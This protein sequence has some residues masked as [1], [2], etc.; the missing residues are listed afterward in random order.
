MNLHST[1]TLTAAAR[2]LLVSTDLLLGDR[3][4]PGQGAPLQALDP[5]TEQVLAT[6]PSASVQQVH[7]AVARAREAFDDG[8]WPRLAPA[9]R[10]RVLARAADLMVQHRQ[11]LMDIAVAEGGT[12]VSQAGA[13]KVDVSV[14]HLRWFAAK[15]AEGPRAGWERELAA[16]ARWPG[17]RSLLLREPIGVVAALTPYNVQYLTTVWKVIGALA[18]GCTTVFMP[19]PRAQLAGIAFAR[20]L[21]MAGLPRGAFNLVLGGPDVGQALTE[22][23]GV[24]LVSFTGSNTVGRKVMVQAAGSFK[25]VVLELGGKSPNV[26]LPGAFRPAVVP[27]SILRFCRSAGQAC[28]ATTRTFVPQAD[29]ERYVQAARE[30]LR[31]FKVGDPWDPATAM[32]PLIRAEHRAGVEGY[33]QR[34]LAAGG[35]IEAGGGRPDV[36]SGFFMNPALVGGVGNDS[37]IAQ[38]E[39][40]G[41]VGV[42]IPYRDVDEAVRL[43]NDTRYGL[44][45]NVWG[46]EREALAVARRIRSGSVTV[47]G[48]GPQRPDAPFGGYKQS[49]FGSEL[50]EEGFCEF[51]QVQHVQVKAG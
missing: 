21:A 33:V 32:G 19:A 43:A 4:T 44:N 23:D 37:E 22:A 42:L 18:A 45:A 7:E 27:A 16:D 34:A 8:P 50:G 26:V 1:P 15:A 49:G 38:E 25:R 10:S 39:L 41:P 5:S 2:E 51:L 36:P 14:D 17:A 28:G 46:E 13:G 31:G 29:Y 9:E 47:N 24:D 40:F 20:V 30:F 11:A 48:G 6:V 35:R 3:W 12:P